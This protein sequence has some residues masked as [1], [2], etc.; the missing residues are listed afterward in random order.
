[1]FKSA[2]VKL[3]LLYVAIIGVICLYFSLNLYDISTKELERGLRAQQ[4]RLNMPRPGRIIDEKKVVDDEL[5]TVLSSGKARIISRLI[6]ANT[7]ILSIG[8]LGSYLLAK[9]T[10]SP[11]EKA[12]EAQKR[13]TADASH[14]LRTPLAT[15]QTEIEVV[16][17]NTS[18]T[19]QQL[20]DVLASN[21]EELDNLTR[22]TNALLN[23][24]RDNT[25][26][27]LKPVKLQQ[28]ISQ[29]EDRIQRQHYTKVVELHNLVTDE[30][31]LTGQHD[32]LVNLFAILFDNAIKYS[33]SKAEITI[34]AKRLRDYVSISVS[35][36]GKGI[37]SKDLGNI[38][39]RFYQGNLS[40]TKSSTSSHGLG[41]S[42][43]KQ[44]V[45]LHKGSIFATSE[46]GK[47]TTFHIKL[48]LK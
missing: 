11:I 19:Q 47:G 41:L 22:L 32:N 30:L 15:M 31:T 12:H 40:R 25:N 2:V 44:I 34:E 36:N 3:T 10:L 23:L 26:T 16:L 4:K 45:D 8:G 13:F 1:M 28:V 17:R 29:A 42:I 27:Q 20:K 14:E 39:E 43:A 21:L 5:E 33:K 7:I 38:F 18:P 37:A 9:K 35:D 46:L 6:F 48:P 24:A